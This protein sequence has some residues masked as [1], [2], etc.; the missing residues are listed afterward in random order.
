ME[1]PKSLFLRGWDD[2]EATKLVHGEDEEREARKGGYK[3]LAEFGAS[4]AG[5]DDAP[6]KRGRKPKALTDGAE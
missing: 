5:A 2:L 4:H 3:S 6:K 1:Y